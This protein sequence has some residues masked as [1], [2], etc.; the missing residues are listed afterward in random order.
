MCVGAEGRVGVRGG[1]AEGRRGI[2]S[3]L[4]SGG[5]GEGGEG[6]AGGSEGLVPQQVESIFLTSS[7]TTAP[8]SLGAVC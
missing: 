6:G 4:E 2:D 5:P 7:S 8:L 1:E 3:A